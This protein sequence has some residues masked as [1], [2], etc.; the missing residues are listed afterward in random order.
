MSAWTQYLVLPI[1]LPEDGMV[2][3][4]AKWSGRMLSC[5][6]KPMVQV[7]IFGYL[8]IMVG[9]CGYEVAA[10]TVQHLL[11]DLIE[12]M[13]PQFHQYVQDPVSGQFSGFH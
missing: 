7:K 11:L 8:T 4:N 1:H 12:R 2:P 5:P 10:C 6:N 13:P 3:Y 9:T